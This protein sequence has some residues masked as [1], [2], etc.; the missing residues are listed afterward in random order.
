MPAPATPALTTDVII[1]L[2]DRPGRP[3]VLIERRF[4]PLGWA[5]P[6]GFVDVGEAVE[7]AAVR[8]A[9]E[10]TSLV[11]TLKALLGVYSDPA[12]DPR[13]HTASAVYVAEA[14]GE[15]RAQDDA[16]NVAVFSLDRMPEALCFDHAR[17]LADYRAY[18]ETGKLPAPRTSI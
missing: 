10:E 11:V 8:E 3:I 9:R 2:A 7:R 5:L 1:E 6:G 4:P 14:R 13:R 17:I 16:K 12:R 18:R 15:P